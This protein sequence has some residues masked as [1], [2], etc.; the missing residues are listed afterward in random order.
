[1]SLALHH[2]ESEVTAL[3]LNYAFSQKIINISLCLYIVAA[4]DV[5]DAPASSTISTYLFKKVSKMKKI[6]L[7]KAAMASAL[8]FTLM[9]N[10]A[11]AVAAQDSAATKALPVPVPTELP[12]GELGKIVALGRDIINNTNTHPLSRQYVGNSLKCTSCHLEAGTNPNVLS[13]LG[14]ASAY[15]TYTPREKKTITLEDRNLNCFMRSMSGV[16]PPNGSEVS[17]AIAAYITWLSEG[18]PVKMSLTG[19]HG[20]NSE[21]ALQID[22]ATADAV[23]GKTL[24]ATVCA[25]C[26]GNDG[27][28]VGTFPPVWGSRSYNQGAGLSQNLKL[29]TFLKNAMPLGNPNLSEKD[30][31][32]IAAYVNA[33][34]RDK[35]VLEEHLGKSK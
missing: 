16:R 13:F 9:I 35:F 31:L 10:V 33:Q 20:P 7:I 24:Y 4:Y 32:D 14:T 3:I 34:P 17:I 11:G 26:H 23:R 27:A 18:Y 1:V 6:T 21:P 15:P 22:A 2:I 8:G 28:G 30:A 25:S 5:T 19:P 12:Q 29:A